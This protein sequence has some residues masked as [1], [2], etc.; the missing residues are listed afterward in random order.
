LVQIITGIDLPC[1]CRSDATSS[2]ITS[3]ALSSAVMR[4]SATTA[5]L[6]NGVVVGLQRVDHPCAPRIGNNVDIGT[7]A[8]VLGDICIGD[9]VIIGPMP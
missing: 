3:A 8:K 5:A 9:N 4:N 6:R 7:G 1:E 2:S